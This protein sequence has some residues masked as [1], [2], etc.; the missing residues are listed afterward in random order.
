M[1]LTASMTAEQARQV[2]AVV[3]RERLRLRN[4][5]RRR[6]ADPAEVDLWRFPES[7]FTYEYYVCNNIVSLPS[8]PGKP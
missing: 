8:L 4:W 7:V 2:S 3:G 6:L 1:A 5:I